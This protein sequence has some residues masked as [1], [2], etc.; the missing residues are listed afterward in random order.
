MNHSHHA[1]YFFFDYETFGTHPGLDRPC[2]FAGV[3]TDE[4]F[5]IISE[6]L[7]IYCRPPPLDYLPPS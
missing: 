2:Q 1:T 5:N 7:V 6:P 4:N 3:R